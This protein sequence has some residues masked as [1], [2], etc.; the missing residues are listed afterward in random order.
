MHWLDNIS[1]ISSSILL[2]LN[3]LNFPIRKRGRDFNS[4]KVSLIYSDS[5][6]E[7]NNSEVVAEVIKFFNIKKIFS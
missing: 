4:L 2:I 5:L 6:A 1:R 7:W 3:L